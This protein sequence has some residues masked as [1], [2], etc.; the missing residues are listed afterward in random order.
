MGPWLR[1]PGPRL[2]TWPLIGRGGQYSALIGRGWPLTGHCIPRPVQWPVWL[3][4]I[5]RKYFTKYYT[6]QYTGSCHKKW[7][8]DIWNGALNSLL[9]YKRLKWFYILS[10]HFKQSSKLPA[11]IPQLKSFVKGEIQKIHICS[12]LP[13]CLNCL[14]NIIVVSGLSS[15]IIIDR[16]PLVSIHWGGK[17]TLLLRHHNSYR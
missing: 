4:L 16:H 17:A 8:S 7:A 3:G 14:L 13:D 10:E 5:W 15:Q 1:N 2:L 9:C 11:L 12:K 6:I